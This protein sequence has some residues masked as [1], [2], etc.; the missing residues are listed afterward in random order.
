MER[1]DLALKLLSFEP[2]LAK[3][4]PLLLWMGSK[5]KTEDLCTKFYERALEEAL[6]S[7]DLNLLFLAIRKTLTS[8]Q[9]PR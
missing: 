9:I 4:I 1:N 8:Q 6:R 3:K 5:Q 7:R 2:S